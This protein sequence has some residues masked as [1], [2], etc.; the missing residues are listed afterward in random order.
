M[1]KCYINNKEYKLSK[2]PVFAKNRIENED[3]YGEIEIVSDSILD[4]AV[5]SKVRL[6]SDM[7]DE[8]FIIQSKPKEKRGAD[9]YH[10][11]IKLVENSSYLN[12]M[13]PEDRS[14]SSYVSAGEVQY[15]SIK[16]IL[17]IY[18]E[19][20]YFYFGYE[21][22]FDEN[23]EIYDT[24]INYEEFPNYKFKEILVQLFEHIDA[25][26]IVEWDRN[27]WYI[28]YEKYNQ[29]KEA[30][31]TKRFTSQKTEE[32]NVDYG[33]S[34]VSK[35][36]N[37]IDLQKGTWF[38]SINGYTR[39]R[40]ATRIFQDSEAEIKTPSRIS[41][42]NQVEA[43]DVIVQVYDED[44]EQYITAKE[45]IDISKQ[46]V[47]SDIWD[48]LDETG[49]TDQDSGVYQE[50][51]IQYDNERLFGFYIPEGGILSFWS[52]DVNMLFNAINTAWRRQNPNVADDAEGN[53][54]LGKDDD[55][56]KW[57]I[58][59]NY[60]SK[61]DIDLQ[62][63]KQHVQGMT[64][65]THLANQEGASV[66]ISRY[67]SNLMAK[68][69]RIG[70]KTEQYNVYVDE[71][72]RVPQIGD[73]TGEWLVTYARYV[74][75]KDFIRCTLMLSKNFTHA[76]RAYA[77]NDE[78]D[79]R[80]IPERAM[81]TNIRSNNYLTVDVGNEANNDDIFTTTAGREAVLGY[82]TGEGGVID[83]ALYNKK[84][85]GEDEPSDASYHMEAE[86]SGSGTA[87]RTHVQFL[88]PISAGMMLV[89]DGTRYVTKVLKYTDD[90][91]R[92]RYIKLRIGNGVDFGDDYDAYDYPLISKQMTAYFEIDD[93]PLFLSPRDNY[94]HTHSL[95]VVAEH[96]DIF[97]TKNFTKL[98]PLINGE[99]P[100]LKI[101]ESND[102]FNNFDTKKREGLDI[103]SPYNYIYTESDQ[104]LEVDI[105]NDHWA[106]ATED[107][108]ILL[109]VNN[110]HQKIVFS[111]EQFRPQFDLTPLI[112]LEGG[113]QT[114]GHNIS[115]QI[116]TTDTFNESVV[117][118]T[119]THGNDVYG[120]L[121]TE[122]VEQ[123]SLNG[124]KQTHGHNIQGVVHASTDISANLT[125]SPQTHG[126]N[127]NGELNIAQELVRELTG[128]Q[129]HGNDVFGNISVRSLQY[130]LEGDT[131]TH[132]NDVYG[133]INTNIT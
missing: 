71:N 112:S 90:E 94:A 30:L 88:S 100:N 6:V 130:D 98:H 117:G 42:I 36:Q 128:T 110:G 26:P 91:G 111:F 12:E 47:T 106:L 13:I 29:R 82:F 11:Q 107:D 84:F 40:S 73:Y 7:V 50:N 120:E 97:V 48:S 75:Y 35:T 39:P 5:Y 116:S 105:T 8:K 52:E 2:P 32:D 1:V 77:I 92:Q 10:Y 54:P 79:P 115:G 124:E 51:T 76:N 74:H 99:H 27:V 59:V 72:D 25:I 96:P 21:I 23:D 86:V 122:L 16:Q 121:S 70:N 89:E 113:T 63:E 101:I 126:Y 123:V 20:L 80:T 55:M 61:R 22:D 37:V 83:G 53:G 24:E 15:H 31:D 44:E 129:T 108:D 45:T 81:Q 41:T 64:Y 18:Q 46:V 131:Q 49:D 33:T 19:T 78:Y 133:T 43:V 38:P 60:L 102:Y 9:F 104:T 109:A 62:Q 34:L 65:S 4:I 17:E 125:G 95:H 87:I 56:H 69:N 14:F 132:G 127:I 58:R 85:L 103:D 118:Q 114:H 66:E 67:E 93:A 28:T 57:K 119:Q 3:W 68:A